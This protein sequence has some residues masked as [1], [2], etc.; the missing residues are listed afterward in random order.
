[1]AKRGC[2]VGANESSSYERGA[3]RGHREGA[4]N[5]VGESRVMATRRTPGERA[6][7]RSVPI[8]TARALWIYLKHR[9]VLNVEEFRRTNTRG[10]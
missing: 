1:M 7:V 5:L 2:T 8:A 9:G 3:S 6:P 4:A 10:L